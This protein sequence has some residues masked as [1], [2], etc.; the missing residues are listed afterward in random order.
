MCSGYPPLCNADR[1]RCAGR[2]PTNTRP[3]KHP[4]RV[5]RLCDLMLYVY[6]RVRGGV[7]LLLFFK[8]QATLNGNVL[9]I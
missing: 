8:L 5:T 3:S 2:G 1:E 9:D 6:V 4:D 7:F